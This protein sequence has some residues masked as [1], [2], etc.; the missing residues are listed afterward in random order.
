MKE[1][2]SKKAFMTLIEEGGDF[3]VDLLRSLAEKYQ[4]D[5]RDQYYD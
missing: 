3:V 4:N 5:E 2:L 1:L